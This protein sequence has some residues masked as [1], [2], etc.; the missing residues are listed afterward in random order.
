MQFI[1]SYLYKLNNELD[2]KLLPGLWL[3]SSTKR[4]AI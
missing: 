4:F 3:N 2:E 1:V